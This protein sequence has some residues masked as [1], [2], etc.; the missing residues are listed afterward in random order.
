MLPVTENIGLPTN[1]KTLKN[2]IET[3]LIR[4]KP[5]SIM[6]PTNNKTLK[7]EIETSL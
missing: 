2:E 6:S 5:K 7:N 4:I 3:S 1:N